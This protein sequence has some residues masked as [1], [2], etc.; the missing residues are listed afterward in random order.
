MKNSFILF[1]GLVLLFII[2]KLSFGVQVFIFLLLFLLA[3]IRKL[4][5]F[6]L[7]K[8]IKYFLFAIFLIYPLTTPGEL[9]FYYS[10]ISISYEGIFIALENLFRLVSIFM[11]VMILMDILPKDFFIR[12]LIKVCYPFTLVGVDIERLSSRIYLT[13]EYLEIFKKNKFTFSSITKD[14]VSQ[15]DSKN[16]NILNNKITIIKPEVIDYIWL[17]FFIFIIILIQFLIL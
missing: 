11:L 12:F 10:F 14:I 15:L 9:I 17:I 7:I 4:S 8:K 2:G 6:A 5:T 16:I 3:G 1:L 13:F